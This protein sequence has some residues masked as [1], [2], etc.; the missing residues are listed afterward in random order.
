MGTESYL[1]G[2]F[3]YEAEC[4]LSISPLNNDIILTLK[5]FP[6]ESSHST[7]GGRLPL[8]VLT[9]SSQYNLKKNLVLELVDRH[10]VLD[11]FYTMHLKIPLNERFNTS[12]TS[13]TFDMSK[14][15]SFFFRCSRYLMLDALDQLSAFGRGRNTWGWKSSSLSL[16]MTRLTFYSQKDH[17]TNGVLTG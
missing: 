14:C 8:E 13:E 9:Y 16:R 3:R 17:S 15:S 11:F 7:K 4:S 12:S 10:W 6:G 1:G 5:C 2:K